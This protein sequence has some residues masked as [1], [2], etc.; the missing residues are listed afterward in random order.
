MTALLVHIALLRWLDS[1]HYVSSSNK[2]RRRRVTAISGLER[3]GEGQSSL[4][5]PK[6]RQFPVLRMTR[7]KVEQRVKE[8]SFCSPRSLCAAKIRTQP[9]L[10]RQIC[11]GNL[12]K[13]F[14]TFNTTTHLT[15][16][17]RGIRNTI[18]QLKTRHTDNLVKNFVARGAI[19]CMTNFL[20]LHLN[21]ESL[22]S[23]TRRA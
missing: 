12:H 14:D 13:T 5:G 22:Q 23:A 21:K 6:T 19:D 7:N 1:E 10:A 15:L 4:V 20:H 11:C 2:L 9:S 3:T 8:L 18:L 17:T 16:N